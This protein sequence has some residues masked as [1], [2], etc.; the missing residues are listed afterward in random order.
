LHYFLF[1]LLICD[2]ILII[3]NPVSGGKKAKRTL[4][5]FQVYARLYNLNFKAYETI[6]SKDYKGIKLAFENI[7]PQLVISCGGDGTANDI[8]NAL[9]KPEYKNEIP[10]LVLPAGSG[11]DFST[12]LYGKIK[13]TDL[14]EK[15]LNYTIKKVDLGLCNQNIF[16]NGIGIGFDGSI[17][18]NT[19][20]NKNRILPTTLKYYLAIFK[21]L[22]VF[23]EFD[24]HTSNDKA[25]RKG[26]IVAISN[27]NSYGGGF[28]IAPKAKLDDGL[29]DVVEIGAVS[30]IKRPIYIPIVEKGKHLN[31]SFVTHHQTQQIEI[32]SGSHQK[33]QAHADGEHFEANTFNV[34]VLRAALPVPV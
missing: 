17:A 29:L 3:Y 13:A 21:N 5:L 1:F 16:L 7:Q 34:E 33:I 11:N 18:Q 10:L 22:F 15:C 24:Y 19:S 14:F 25:N 20:S 9:Y 8:V 31:L 26:F 2:V 12:Q 30:K 32:K 27:G 28:K 4:R 23:N 6:Q